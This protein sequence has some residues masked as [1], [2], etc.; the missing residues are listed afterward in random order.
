MIKRILLLSLVALF[1]QGCGPLLNLNI[2]VI[3]EQTSLENQVLG[4]YADLGN[5]LLSYSSVRGV[6][7]SGDLNPPPETTESQRLVFAALQNRR[8]NSD[9]LILLLRSKILGE[10]ADGFVVQRSQDLKAVSLTQDQVD[11]LITEENADR[12][13]LLERLQKT[14]FSE[15]ENQEQEI[16]WIFATINQDAAPT[17]TPV[18]SRDGKW[19]TK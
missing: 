19:S 18:Q 17:G 1:L 3:G 11:Q 7:P 2:K 5:E 9:D 13:V 10:G 4:N 16:R 12:N 8:Y 14:I 6:D 15:A